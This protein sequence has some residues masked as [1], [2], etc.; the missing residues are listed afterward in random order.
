MHNINCDEYKMIHTCTIPKTRRK[1]CITSKT[2]Q[3]VFTNRAI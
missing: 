2:C 1:Y 3:T